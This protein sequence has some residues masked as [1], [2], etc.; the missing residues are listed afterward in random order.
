M[1]YLYNLFIINFDHKVRCLYVLS[2]RAMTIMVPVVE[3]SLVTVEYNPMK[4]VCSMS[5]KV[6]HAI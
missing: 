1:D 6:F 5:L 3:H 2:R 4:V